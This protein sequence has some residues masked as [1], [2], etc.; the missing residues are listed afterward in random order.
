MSVLSAQSIRKLCLERTPALISPFTERGV[1]NGK[2]F[3]L[4]ACSYDVRIDH[5]L[6]L[7]AK[8]T[9]LASTIERFCFPDN[10]CGSVLDKSSYARMFVSAFNTHFDAG[11]E[12]YATI[13]LVNLGDDD[14]FFAEGQPLCQFKFEWLDHPTDLPYRGKYYMQHRGPQPAKYEADQ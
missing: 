11:F 12:G 3:G 7:R 10:V 13:E 4:S 5:C 6:L 1:F 2:S 14:V 8:E 9:A